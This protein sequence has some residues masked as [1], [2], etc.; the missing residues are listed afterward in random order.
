MQTLRRHMCDLFWKIAGEKED[1]VLDGIPGYHPKAQFVAGKVINQCSYVL[2]D[3]LMGTEREDEAK[4]AL[5][6]IVRMVSG[7]PMETWGILNGIEGLWR[8]RQHG[9][10]ET[11]VD[12]DT[13]DSLRA[14]MDWRTFVDVSADYALIH[15]PTNYYG[16]AFGIARYRELLGWD[17]PGAA[18]ILLDHLLAHIR[19]YSGELGFMDETQGD[20]RFDRYSLL[21]PGELTILLLNTGWQVP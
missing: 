15:K 18:R 2:T 16:V 21:V 10:L 11:L 1:I 17:E 4:A 12:A 8:L 9:L 13:L 7:M 3:C 19:R 5:T 20:G 6:G 14:S